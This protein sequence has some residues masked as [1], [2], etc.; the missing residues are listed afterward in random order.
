MIAVSKLLRPL[1]HFHLRS[2]SNK[3]ELGMTTRQEQHWL[4]T[5]AAQTYRG[6]GAIVDLGCFLGASTIALA[7]GLT[8][9]SK[10]RRVPIHAYDLFIW[11]ECYEAWR[12]RKQ[13]EVALAP[14]DSFL[15][16]FLRRTRKW[17][18]QIVV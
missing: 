6:K 17:R 11:D 13:I 18:D 15:P 1:R 16:E 4:R 7:Q 14:G 12:K 8:L 5:Y 10:A 2:Q 9:N 3:E